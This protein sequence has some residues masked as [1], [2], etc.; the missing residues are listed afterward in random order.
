MSRAFELGMQLGLTKE[1]RGNCP[2][3]KLR[4]KGEGRGMGFGKGKGP[5]GKPG[6]KRDWGKM[7][8]KQRKRR[9]D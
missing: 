7:L 4:S 6:K 3:G 2:G 5:I 1:A 9:G 8:E